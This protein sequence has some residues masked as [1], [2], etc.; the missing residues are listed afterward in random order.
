MFTFRTLRKK[1]NRNSV[2]RRFPGELPNAI[3]RIAGIPLIFNTVPLTSPGAALAPRFSIIDC[4]RGDR[5]KAKKAEKKARRVARVYRQRHFWRHSAR[6]HGDIILQPWIPRAILTNRDFAKMREGAS[7]GKEKRRGERE[8]GRGREREREKMH[9]LAQA[10]P[11][12][13]V[14]LQS[15]RVCN[16]SRDG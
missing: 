5:G 8:R 15:A 3:G 16:R 11:P 13:K 7:G 1:K 10:S 4:R 2:K 14:P 9:A 12:V 6:F